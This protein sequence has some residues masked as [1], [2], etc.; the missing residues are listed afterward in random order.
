V[1]VANPE[2]TTSLPQPEMPEPPD[3]KLTVP[4]APKGTYA[5]NVTVE[6]RFPDEIC[7]ATSVVVVVE[8]EGD[9][10]AELLAEG[11]VPPALHAATLKV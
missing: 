8:S 9:V 4:V 11:P 3:L 5:V 6:P 1:H 7:D 10:A 2:V